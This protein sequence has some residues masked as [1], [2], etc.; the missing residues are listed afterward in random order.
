MAAA[1]AASLAGCLATRE[2]HDPRNATPGSTGDEL[3]ETGSPAARP[4][5]SPGDAAR[6]FTSV[7]IIAAAALLAMALMEDELDKGDGEETRL[8]GDGT[9]AGLGP[10]MG[11]ARA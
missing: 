3:R 2:D 5:P 11:M 1:V 6:P 8:G 10:A 7:I 4:S 9:F